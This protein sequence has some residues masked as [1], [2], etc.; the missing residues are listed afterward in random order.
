MFVELNSLMMEPVI[1]I[2]T[3]FSKYVSAAQKYEICCS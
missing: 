3:I 2:L 1:N